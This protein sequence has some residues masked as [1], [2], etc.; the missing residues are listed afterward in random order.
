M[1]QVDEEY[2]NIQDKRVVILS[3][4]YLGLVIQQLANNN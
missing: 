2:K 4:N 1:F 3:W